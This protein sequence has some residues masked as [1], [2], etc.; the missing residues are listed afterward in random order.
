MARLGGL[1]ATT[2]EVTPVDEQVARWSA[3]THD[4]VNRVIERLLDQ[5][6]AVAAVGPIDDQLAAAFRD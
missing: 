2:G 5:P 3:V 6:L 1:L 4:D